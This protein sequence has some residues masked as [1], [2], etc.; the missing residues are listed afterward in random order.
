MKLL[1]LALAA[2]Q[3]VAA[4]SLS[5]LWDATVKVKDVEVPFR[6]EIASDGSKV[7]GTFFNGDAKFVSSAGSLNNGALLINWDYTA[8]RLEATVHDGVI[9]G[10]Y[11]RAGRDAKTVYPFHA[12]RFSPSTVPSEDVPSIAGLWVIPTTS[13]K[14]ESAWQFIVRQSGPE[15]TAA[16]LRI[17]G[18]TGALQGTYRDGKFILSHFSGARPAVFE[19]K[20]QPDGSIDILQNGTTQLTATRTAEARLKGLPEPTDPSKHT[21]VK[22]PTK[23]F[24]F[25]LNDLSGKTVTNEDPRF[26]GKV[27]LINITGSWCPNCHDEAPFLAALYKKYHAQGLEIVALSFEEADQL[28]DPARL[29]AFIK[30]YGIDYTVLVG[31]EPSEAKDKLT[32]A[33]NWNAWPTT[34]FIGRDGLVRGAHAGFPSSGSGEIFTKAKEDFTAKVER[35]LAEN[36]QSSR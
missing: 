11:Y 30:K 22:D 20:P 26:R 5:G 23:P 14:G 24:T 21:S 15:V 18:D 4:Q 9:D 16:I 10:N 7:A 1:T 36:V 12:K 32:N 35:L 29:R 33:V 25:A 34:F 19:V 6:F 3:F 31:G 17:D 13:D 2:T 27:V 28:K 8:S